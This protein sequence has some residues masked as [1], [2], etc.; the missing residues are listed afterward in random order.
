MATNITNFGVI[1]Y[2]DNHKEVNINA[3]NSN[4]AEIIRAF[5]NDQPIE[6]VQPVQEYGYKATFPRKGDYNAVREYVEQRMK[7]DEVFRSFCNTHSRKQLC[8]RLSDEF[9]WE[10]NTNSYIKS[11]NRKH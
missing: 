1:N 4:T 7:E 9:G 6:D 10:V 11:M 5:M 8:E 2:N 3:E